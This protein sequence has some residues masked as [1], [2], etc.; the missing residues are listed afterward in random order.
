MLKFIP[1]NAM[2]SS[3]VADQRLLPLLSEVLQGILEAGSARWSEIARR[4]RGSE[5]AAYKRIQRLV[6]RFDP[7]PVVTR[8]CPEQAPFVIADRTEVERPHAYRTA[9][10]GLLPPEKKPDPGQ[11]QASKARGKASAKPKGAPKARR[12]PRRGF[13]LLVLGV[14][15]R[16]RVLPCAWRTFSSRTL[17]AGATSQNL[18]VERILYTCSAK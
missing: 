9:Y 3:L 14:P 12:K 6:A 16:G 7:W 13:W 8:L 1:W 10:V 5:A 15:F 17:E 2:L 4:M 18:E 11:R